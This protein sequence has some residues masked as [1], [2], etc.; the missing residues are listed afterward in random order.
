L[1]TD[2]VDLLKRWMEQQGGQ[3]PSEK[4]APVNLV[5]VP[6]TDAEKQA[7]SKL[8]ETG[9]MVTRVAQNVN[10]LR[11]S[12]RLQGNQITDEDIAP[13]AEME[14]LIEIDLANTGVTDAALVHLKELPNLTHL[15]LNNTAI[16]DDGLA[17]LSNLNNLVYLNLY[18]TQV[19]DAGL[20]QLAGLETLQKLYLW[21]TEVSEQGVQQFQRARPATQVIRGW[22]IA[23]KDT[24]S[25]EE[26]QEQAKK[27]EEE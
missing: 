15:D 1:T 5:E 11:A 7:I 9:A 2:E 3:W 25:E 10:W 22:D 21:Q 18:G 8:Q 20:E 6:V 24:E 23:A 12:F 13:L 4:P 16:T 26:T 14:N 17:H 27:E 19:T